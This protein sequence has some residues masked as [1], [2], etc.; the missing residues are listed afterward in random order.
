MD[1]LI[2]FHLI[3]EGGQFKHYIC[4]LRFLG[5]LFSAFYFFEFH[6]VCHFQNLLKASHLLLLSLHDG[7]EKQDVTFMNPPLREKSAWRNLQGKKGLGCW[8]HRGPGERGQVLAGIAYTSADVC[9]CH[10]TSSAGWIIQQMFNVK[11]EHSE[12]NMQPL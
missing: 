11:A 4:C 2:M 5:W 6:N 12:R 3:R 10:S 8:A 1:L 9:W 7:R